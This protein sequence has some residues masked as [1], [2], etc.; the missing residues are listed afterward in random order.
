MYVFFGV[1]LVSFLMKF[2]TFCRFFIIG[3]SG[4]SS[5]K[6]F[7]YVFVFLLMMFCLFL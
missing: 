6:I 7:L 5:F 3:F 4:F 2:I 1:C